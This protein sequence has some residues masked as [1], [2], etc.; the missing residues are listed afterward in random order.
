MSLKDRK[1]RPIRPFS[2]RPLVPTSIYPSAREQ[3]S[4]A[5]QTPGHRGAQAPPSL[6]P[7]RGE[8]TWTPAEVS[9]LPPM[10]V[11]AY[12]EAVRLLLYVA[13]CVVALRATKWLAGRLLAWGAK[14][15]RGLPCRQSQ[16][17]SSLLYLDAGRDNQ[18]VRIPLMKLP[19]PEDTVTGVQGPEPL[20]VDPSAWCL[21]KTQV[22]WTR[23]SF[24]I[25]QGAMVAHMPPPRVIP[26]RHPDLAGIAN[27][28]AH[29]YRLYLAPIQNS[30]ARLIGQLSIHGEDDQYQEDSL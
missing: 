13:A 18:S 29:W 25:N 17:R 22:T 30:K 3:P 10:T 26:G 24:E 8:T 20:F 11:G 7:P 19:F 4:L 14:L 23:G 15:P 27:N 9:P 12:G 5:T 2:Q 1:I 16:P 6:R 28:G 21:Q